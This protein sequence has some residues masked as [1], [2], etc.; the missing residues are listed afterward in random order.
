MAG[1]LTTALSAQAGSRVVV[2]TTVD[3]SLGIFDAG[4]LGEL[5][6]P[7]PSRGGGPV[8]LWVQEFD[9]REYLFAAN[10]GAVLGSV[11]VF[12]LSGEQVTELP[13]SPF[14][15]RA[16][17]VGIAAG[18][19][20]VGATQG[21]GV[22]VTNTQSAVAAGAGFGCSLPNGRVTGSHARLPFPL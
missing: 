11:G 15:A 6:S 14:P 13:L 19:L 3:R 20:T 10:H 18:E 9:G 2:W 16:G 1:V 21:P 4:S 22:L 17:S 7:V 12:D 8:R 5:Q